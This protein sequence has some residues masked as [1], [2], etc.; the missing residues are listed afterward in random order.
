MVFLQTIETCA[1]ELLTDDTEVGVIV[2]WQDPTTFEAREST[3][4]V[5][6]AELLSADPTLLHKGLAIYE[7]AEALKV[8]RDRSTPTT[9]RAAAIVAAADAVNAALSYDP[10]DLDLAEVQVVLDHL[11]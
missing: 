6:M 2:T 4:T 5:S 8:W 9:E 1:P 3:L 10:D 11:E 7:Y